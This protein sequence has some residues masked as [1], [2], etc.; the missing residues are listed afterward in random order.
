MQGGRDAGMQGCRERRNGR[1]TVG[2]RQWTVNGRERHN[3]N[4]TGD[5]EL[6]RTGQ[7]GSR[8]Q[9]G[10]GAGAGVLPLNDLLWEGHP[11]PDCGGRGTAVVRTQS[12]GMIG[13][14]PSLC[15][16][17]PVGEGLGV[18]QPF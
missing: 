4:W 15:S 9:G 3:G 7:Q 10:R 5:W 12:P 2:S 11:W 14:V 8:R 1:W 16:P 18:R 6:E 17:L 13:Q